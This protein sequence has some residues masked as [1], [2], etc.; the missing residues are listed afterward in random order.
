VESLHR[1]FRTSHNRSAPERSFSSKLSRDERGFTIIELLLVILVIGI[2]SA[3]AI[4]SFLSSKGKALDV[5]AKELVRTAETTAET[6]AAGNSGNY[7]KVTA[8]E[9]NKEEPSI[10]ILASTGQAYLSGASASKTGYSLTVTA[11]DGNEFTISKNA[12]GDVTRQCV[13]TVLKNG[14]GGSETSSW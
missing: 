9:L 12:T 1:R 3:I 8:G 7:E 11:T 14:C 4:P 5:Q 10:R 6:V 13:S 2:L